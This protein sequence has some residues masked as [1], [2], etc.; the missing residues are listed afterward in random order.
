MEIDFDGKVV[1]FKPG[2]GMFIPAGEKHKHNAKALTDKV[3]VILVE[4][5]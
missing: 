1:A 3:R 2:D 5:V 4:D